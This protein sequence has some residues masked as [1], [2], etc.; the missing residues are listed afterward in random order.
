MPIVQIP[1]FSHQGIC[2]EW[3]E[4]L[5]LSS[6][7]KKVKI[8]DIGARQCVH[9]F[10]EHEDQVWSVAYNEDGSQAVSCSDDKSICVLN[11]Q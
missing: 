2:L 8:W 4:F 1:S 5:C 10:N 9:T 7:D 11:C 3:S 6:S